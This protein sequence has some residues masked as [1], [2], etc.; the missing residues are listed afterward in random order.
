MCVCK[1]RQTGTSGS[2]HPRSFP[3]FPFFS[4]RPEL[5][6]YEF[7]AI[8]FLCARSVRWRKR[9]GRRKE[10][11][12]GDKNYLCQNVGILLGFSWMANMALAVVLVECEVEWRA[13]GSTGLNGSCN[14]LTLNCWNQMIKGPD[15]K[16][17]WWQLLHIVSSPSPFILFPVEQPAAGVW[18]V[19]RK[20]KCTCVPSFTLTIS[21]K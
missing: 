14:G 21:E 15:Y 8:H 19:R 9:S 1:R 12:D 11:E 17:W 13:C 7:L 18:V 5:G 16:I 3:N 10:G 4:C 20:R 6:S 2:I